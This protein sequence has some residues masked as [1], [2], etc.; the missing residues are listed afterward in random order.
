MG[1]S[2][3]EI[4]DAGI[5]LDSPFSGSGVL[6]GTWMFDFE[7]GIESTNQRE[8]DVWWEQKTATERA[9]VPLN[10]ATICGMGIVD[11]NAVS[12]SD[13]QRLPLST[14]PITANATGT[15]LLPTGSTFA[16]RT[17]HGQ[18]IK[19]NVIRYDYNLQMQWQACT[20]P[21]NYLDVKIVLGNAPA[22]LVTRYVVECTYP[23]PGGPKPCGSGVYGPD[24]GILQGKVSDETGAFPPSVTVTVIVDF[25]PESGVAPI[26]K[27]FTPPVT[28]TGANFIFEP[29]SVIQKTD[30]FFDLPAVLACRGG[31][32]SNQ[33]EA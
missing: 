18:F 13:F 21:I 27:T 25:T 23:A 14:A 22:S 26:T 33:M 20:R 28:N 10:G 31:F 8:V 11:Y 24:G 1:V 16:V 17:R 30:L 4:V 7:A 5:T 2:I 12:Y 29:Y 9:M 15:N 32:L 6:R 19:V 3:V